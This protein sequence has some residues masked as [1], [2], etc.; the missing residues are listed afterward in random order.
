MVPCPRCGGQVLRN[1]EEDACL[2][3]GHDPSQN[4]QT[5]QP[6]IVPQRNSKKPIIISLSAKPSQIRR[7]MRRL[8]VKGYSEKEAMKII[9]QQIGG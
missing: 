9:K 4:G 1:Y 5:P 6:A 2:Q 7:R 3:C 8:V